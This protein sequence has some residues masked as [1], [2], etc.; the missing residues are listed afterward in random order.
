MANVGHVR[1]TMPSSVLNSEKLTSIVNFCKAG[2]PTI[3]SR[4]RVTSD[5][6]VLVP[7]QL[8]RSVAMYRKRRLRRRL[9]SGSRDKSNR[10]QCILKSLSCLSSRYSG[11]IRLS[12]CLMCMIK[13]QA[14]SAHRY[15][16]LSDTTRRRT[17]FGITFALL[18]VLGVEHN[19]IE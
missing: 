1:V 17:D 7:R 8:L 10:L 16:T 6:I 2:R 19:F 12:A 4:T 18:P 13:Q 11:L 5:C 3:T 9:G 15:Q 14:G